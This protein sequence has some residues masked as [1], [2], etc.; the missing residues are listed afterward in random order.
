VLGAIDVYVPI[1]QHAVQA[2]CQET[3][4]QNIIIVAH[5]MGGLVARAYLRDH[6]EQHHIARVITLGT[7]HH[8][9][10]LANYSIGINGQQMRCHRQHEGCIPD[11]WLQQLST[12]EPET[13]RQLFV[14]IYSHHDNI[15]APQTS[16]HL[17]GA[18]NIAFRGIG[19]VALGLHPTIQQRV[20]EEIQQTSST[21]IA[22]LKM[23]AA[24]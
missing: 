5:S 17:A 19:H 3:G 12:S 20:I 16:S 8:G 14:S 24:Q 15:I 2:L 7:P 4:Q 21:V 18:K 22:S 23:H 11:P 1:V 10:E 13:R 9:T 6:A